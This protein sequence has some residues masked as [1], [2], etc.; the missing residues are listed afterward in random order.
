MMKL[1]ELG[2]FLGDKRRA[3]RYSQERVAEI[4]GVSDRTIRNIEYGI[5]SPDLTT[6]IK[7]WDLYNLP[8]EQLFSF[9]ARTEEMN[10]SIMF[11]ENRQALTQKKKKKTTVNV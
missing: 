10:D 5:T 7:L 11:Y 9:Y 4:V 6:I 2:C 3:L 8:Y 1:V